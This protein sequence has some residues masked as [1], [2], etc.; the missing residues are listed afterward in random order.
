MKTLTLLILY[1][2][3]CQFSFSQ[4]RQDIDSLKREINH[5]K[6]DTNRVLFLADL[7][8]RYRDVNPDSSLIYGKQ[9]LDLAQK[10]KFKR[11]ESRAFHTLGSTNRVLGDLPKGLNLT[12]KGLLIA[13]EN[14]YANETARCLNLIAVINRDLKD[15]KKALI[16]FKRAWKANQLAQNNKDTKYWDALILSN[17]ANFYR[18]NKQ[19]DSALLFYQKAIEIQNRF[20]LKPNPI[21]INNLGRAYFLLGKPQ[22]AIVCLHQSIELCKKSD[23]H[24]MAGYCYFTIANYFKELNQPDSSIYY[25]KIGLSEAQSIG[26]KDGI[27]LNSSLLANLY[28]T[29]DIKQAYA[30][31][32]IATMTAEE[33][34]GAKKVQ[35]LQKTIYEEYERQRK[36]ETERIAYE[37]RLKQ[38][39]LLA[40]LGITFLVGFILYRNNQKEKKAKNLLHQQK[41]EIQRAL[42]QLK[43]TQAQLI[44]KEKL[45]SL[46]ELTAGI[47]HEIQNPLNFVNNFSEVSQELVE[48]VLEERKKEEG[49]RDEGLINELLSD[50]SQNQ[51][52]IN[53]HGKRA[54]GIVSAMLEHS[55]MSTG[56]RVPTDINRLADEYLRL[57]YHGM[58]AKD[59]S[60][61]ADYE[62]IADPNLP[63]IN[64][65]SQEIGRVLPN[66]I[67]NAFYA[68]QQRFRPYSR[69]VKVEGSPKV[70]VSTKALENA[71]EIRVKDNGNGIPMANLA[72]IF[73][74]FFTTK[75]TGEGTGLGLSLSY[76]IITKGHGGTLEVVS[77][78][79]E[80]S[81]FVI[82]LNIAV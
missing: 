22:Q 30:Y 38:L 2:L 19:L 63:K 57:A 50:L 44:Q 10:L 65:V 80:G 73:Q 77:V 66:L 39:A 56:E 9:A 8:N 62:L 55:R 49:T 46:G 51:E 64:V 1:S 4:T 3:A 60:F 31:Q 74:P 37:N 6:Q 29:R 24:R 14:H 41:E 76:D 69:A 16:Y 82:C 71:I 21:L 20:T 53:H 42:S 34:R 15:G 79:D 23:D 32:K 43:S 67:N 33:V 48:D 75:P 68:T 17:M 70:T 26:F 27:I 72:K 28:E 78:E 11:G 58:R 36:I 7:S 12:Y 35:E 59:S 13:E 61:N 81:E 47:A 40:G 54:S 25:S 5:T 52:K 18:D 45:A